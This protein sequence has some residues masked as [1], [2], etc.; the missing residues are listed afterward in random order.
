MPPY[1]GSIQVASCYESMC[2]YFHRL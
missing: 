1:S 2:A